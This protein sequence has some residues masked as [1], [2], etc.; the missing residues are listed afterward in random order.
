MNKNAI[1]GMTM[2]LMMAMEP[3]PVERQDKTRPG[4]DPFARKRRKKDRMAKKN[5]KINRRK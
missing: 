4:R 5:R 2:G 1:L 3:P